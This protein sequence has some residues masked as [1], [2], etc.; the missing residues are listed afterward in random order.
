MRIRVIAVGTRLP[1][2]AETAVQDFTRRMPRE[3]QVEVQTVAAEP[4]SK[5]PDTARIMRNEATRIRAKMLPGSRV[6]VLD[7]HGKP[8]TTRQWAQA[9]EAWM[10]EGQDVS[11]LI[12]GADGL[13]PALRASGDPSVALSPLTLPHALA[14]VVLA[15]ALYRAWSLSSGHPYHRE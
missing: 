6:V 10:G 5:K 12:G 2:W 8:W 4:R 7:E 13:E 15:E 9:L 3:C 1:D 11:M 14:R